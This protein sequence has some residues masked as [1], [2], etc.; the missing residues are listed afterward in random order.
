M[1]PR[2]SNTGRAEFID[3]G[4]RP[5]ELAQVRRGHPDVASSAASLIYFYDL[6]MQTDRKSSGHALQLS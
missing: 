3:L 6:D 2:S 1:P 4:E 5:S